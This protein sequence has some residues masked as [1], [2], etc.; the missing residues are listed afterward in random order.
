MDDRTVSCHGLPFLLTCAALTLASLIPAGLRAEEVPAAARMG[1][2]HGFLLLRDANGKVIATGDQVDVA[3]GNRVRA[4]LT[5]HF[6]DGSVDDEEAIFSQGRTFQLIHDHH[7]Q[8][9]P[10]FPKP[11]DLTIDVPKGEVT[12]TEDSKKGPQH[13]HMDLPSDLVNG[14]VSLAVQNF[15]HGAGR[16][17]V[18]Y[19]VIESG[20]RVVHFIVTPDGSDKTLIGSQSR[21]ARRFN[22]HIEIG[23]V[24]GVLASAFG[25]QPPD[26]KM[27]VLGPSVPVFI[28]LAGALYEGGPVWTMTLAAPSWTENGR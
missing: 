9:G 8:K 1:T 19:L 18:S 5:F 4:R 12:W 22:V 3:E 20:P 26:F 11:L 2:L 27:W 25:K 24:A 7:V 16:M 10:S 15:P 13:K 6:L 17:Q 14:M 28:K 23:G 21:E